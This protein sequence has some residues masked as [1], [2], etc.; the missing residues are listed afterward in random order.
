MRLAGPGEGAGAG[1]G[2]VAGREEA[3]LAVLAVM[4]IL[5]PFWRS[6]AY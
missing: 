6:L 1:P 3:L 5:L 4:K 2:D